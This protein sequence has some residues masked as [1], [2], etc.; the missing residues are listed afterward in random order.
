MRDITG[1]RRAEREREEAA[2]TAR[3]LAAIVESSGEAILSKDLDLRITS[4]NRAAERMFGYMANEAIG[5]PDRKSVVEDRCSEEEQV[6]QS[7]RRGEKVEHHETERRLK[8]GTII[9]VSL[10]V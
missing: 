5:Q 4:W 2:R 8:D 6:M 1:R 3:Q 7:I 9:P 10:T